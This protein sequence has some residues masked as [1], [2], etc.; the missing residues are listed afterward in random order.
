VTQPV[1]AS[2]KSSFK[3]DGLGFVS[4]NFN[5][6]SSSNFSLIGVSLKSVNSENDF[7]KVNLAGAYAVGHPLMSYLNFK[8][9]FINAKLESTLGNSSQVIFGRRMHLWS[10]AEE[11]WNLGIFQPQFRWN[12]IRPTQQGLTG[13]FWQKKEKSWGFLVFGSPVFIPDQGA[14]Y[15]IKNGQFQKASPWFKNPPQNLNFYGDYLPIEYDI[16]APPLSDIVYQQSYGIQLELGESQGF[17]SRLSGQYRPSYQMALGYQA[18]VVSAVSVNV[19]VLP[20]TYYENVVGLDLGWKAPDQ[21][22]SLS[23]VQSRPQT[24]DFS[25]DFTKPI[26]KE[27]N[28]V[29]AGYE[30]TSHFRRLDLRTK[31][32]YLTILGDPVTDEGTDASELQGSLS[33]KYFYT[34][35]ARLSV[36]SKY[37]VTNS[38]VLSSELAWTQALDSKFKQMD[39]LNRVDFRGP[40]SV[41][42]DF[43]FVDS[44]DEK[45]PTFALKDLDQI[46]L[47]VGYEF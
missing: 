1:Q 36:N 42:L 4:E 43:Y 31:L 2:L 26:I 39:I 17:Y 5:N 35:A 3:A 16:Q 15:E 8:E 19:E 34:E 37:F 23:F 11:E 30:L 12:P 9:F 29:A 41:S 24:P 40:W 20:K 38:L 28:V 45:S 27:S 46:W 44:Q 14:S 21:N 33:W 7:L 18:S 22:V 6:T 10:E 13:L 25:Q 32:N 47:G